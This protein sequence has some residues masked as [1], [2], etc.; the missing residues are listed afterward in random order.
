MSGMKYNSD[1]SPRNI[2]KLATDD[3]S[4]EEYQK[5]E[6]VKKKT[7]AEVDEKFLDYFKVDQNRGSSCRG[8][9]T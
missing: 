2:I 6:D 9:A 8:N 4:V 1:V 7:Q 3:M 5:L